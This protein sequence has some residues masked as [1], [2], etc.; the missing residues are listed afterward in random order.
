MPKDT[1][2]AKRSGPSSAQLREQILAARAIQLRRFQGTG[3]LSN[4]DIA[5]AALDRFCTLTDSARK[6]LDLAL[7]A[8]HLSARSYDRILRVAR[9]CADLN[10]HA[11]ITDA[12]VSEACQ[13]RV[14]DQELRAQDPW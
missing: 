5:G 10:G 11:E 7:N 1:L 3:I 8:K 2:T 9:T 6:F 12:E 13:Y 14:L 4:A